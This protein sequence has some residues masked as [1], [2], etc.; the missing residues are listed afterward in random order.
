MVGRPESLGNQAMKLRLLPILF[1]LALMAA[2]AVAETTVGR[3]CDVPWPGLTMTFA[4]VIL[5]SGSLELRVAGSEGTR[6]VEPL[7]EVGGGVYERLRKDGKPSRD[8]YR[9]DGT[10]DLQLLDSTEG[11]IRTARRLANTPKPGECQ[12]RGDE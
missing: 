6:A 2:P 4:I 10:G 1:V 11:L 8:R 5:D 3:W 9:I 12:W 7:R